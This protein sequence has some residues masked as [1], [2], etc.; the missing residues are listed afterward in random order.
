MNTWKLPTSVN[1]AGVSY[2]IET[3][4][5]VVLDVISA[6]NNPNY[7]EEEKM[8][9]FLMAMIKDFDNLP[10][11][12]YQDAATELAEFIDMGLKDDMPRPV[13][14]DWEQD[15]TL[16]IPEINKQIG[17][18]LDVRAMNMHWWTF[19]GYYMGIGEGTFAHVV[20]IRYKKAKGKKLEKWEKDFIRE[21]KNM[22]VLKPRLSDDEKAEKERLLNILNRAD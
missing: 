22:V 18:G 4:Y 11:S 9:Y 6:L 16:I 7:D 10:E 2:D 17:N 21:N 20:S 19:L 12:Q 8:I 5:K 3:D 13:T 14:M 15:A 1:V